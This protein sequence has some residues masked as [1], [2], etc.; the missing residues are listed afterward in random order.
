MFKASEDED[1]VDVAVL[2]ETAPVKV[3]EE[4]KSKNPCDSFPDVFVTGTIVV[5]VEVGLNNELGATSNAE[6]PPAEVPAIT[7]AV[8]AISTIPFVDVLASG[9]PATATPST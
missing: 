5:A 4:V 6:V 3:H 7:S 9:A 2:T 1:A 8:V